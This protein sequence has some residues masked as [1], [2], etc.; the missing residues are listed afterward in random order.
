MI[1]RCVVVQ[2]CVYCAWITHTH[3]LV[4][5][6]WEMRRY[7]RR[8]CVHLLR[9]SLII[10]IAWKFSREKKSDQHGLPLACYYQTISGQIW[11]T[12][13]T[14]FHA[15]EL[16]STPITN[17]QIRAEF[18][19]FQS[20]TNEKIKTD[21]LIQTRED[22]EKYDFTNAA[23]SQLISDET[24]EQKMWKKLREKEDK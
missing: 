4:R 12:I 9:I 8:K 3:V 11:N 16:S 18:K 13:C 6:V 24:K 19:Q 15:N 14:S 20:F 7:V 5:S 17:A 22:G 10:I 23:N 1:I 2:A 21:L